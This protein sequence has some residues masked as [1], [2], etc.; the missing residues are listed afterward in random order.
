[1]YLLKD[2]DFFKNYYKIVCATPF[3]NKEEFQNK[4]P[5][6]ISLEKMGWNH[7]TNIFY[8]NKEGLPKIY[9]S[10][11][12][13]DNQGKKII[14]LHHDVLIDD[15]L[16]FEKLEIAFE[17]YDIVGLAGSKKCN[18][19]SPMS[20]WHLMC[21][22]EDMVGEVSHSKEKKH[23]TT[24]FGPTDSRALILDG[25]FIAVDVDKLLETNT[26]FD[27]NFD[28]H[29]YDISFCL[30]ANQNKLKM[31]VYPIKLTHFGMGDS[32]H[33]DSWR[34]SAEKFKKLYVN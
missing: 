24:V 13:K 16:I 21:D 1:M 34:S 5:L 15:I 18:I 6:S 27:E 8:D 20:A 2:N 17:K 29:H 9:N 32:M 19:K 11:L 25:V 22:R 30:R 4:S 33:S 3:K 28:F 12:N 7:I 14:F 10:F 26:T 31:G 23:W